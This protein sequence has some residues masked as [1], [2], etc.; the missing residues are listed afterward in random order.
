MKMIILRYDLQI[1]ITIHFM[2]FLL[3]FPLRMESLLAIQR[4]SELQAKFSDCP[5][6]FDAESL[7]AMAHKEQEPPPISKP[8]KL[9][10]ANNK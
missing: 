2:K 1:F 10:N 3:N 5:F 6:A 8:V 7:L 4:L 9:R